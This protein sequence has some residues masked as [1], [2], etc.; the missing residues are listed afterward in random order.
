MNW[1]TDAAPARIGRADGY[2][3]RQRPD[4]PRPP[5]GERRR[6]P[7]YRRRRR[8]TR[9]PARSRE[10][11]ARSAASSFSRGEVGQA[12]SAAAAARRAPPR[13]AGVCPRAGGAAGAAPGRV[14]RRLTEAVHALAAARR[15]RPWPGDGLAARGRA[16]QLLRPRAAGRRSRAMLVATVPSCAPA[17]RLVVVAAARRV[18]PLLPEIAA[19]VGCDGRAWGSRCDPRTPGRC[20]A[21]ALAGRLAGARARRDPA[22]ARGR[23]RLAGPAVGA[24]TRDGRNRAVRRT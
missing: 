16:R 14:A 17:P 22:A 20:G 2:G 8:S 24:P 18:R 5:A 10:R 13:P 6:R 4:L 12:L 7:G 3:G 9:R 11:R 15:R 21:A 1:F 19:E 23:G